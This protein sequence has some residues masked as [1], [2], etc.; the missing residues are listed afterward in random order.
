MSNVEISISYVCF[1][2]NILEAKY[3]SCSILLWLKFLEV[4]INFKDLDLLS[5]IYFNSSILEV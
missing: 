2:S 1:I 4:K 5:I 3:K